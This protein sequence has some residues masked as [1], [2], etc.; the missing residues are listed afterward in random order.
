MAVIPKRRTEETEEMFAELL[1]FGREGANVRDQMAALAREVDLVGSAV[2]AIADAFGRILPAIQD[3]DRNTCFS[4]PFLGGAD[5]S[6][7]PR[8]HPAGPL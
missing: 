8:H 1:E 5:S 3:G 7:T 2:E 6:R 4:K